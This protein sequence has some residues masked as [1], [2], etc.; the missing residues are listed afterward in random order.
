MRW[1]SPFAVVP[2]ALA[3]VG[4]VAT[5]VVVV[6]FLKNFDTPVVKASGREL[7]F[8]LFAGFIVCYLQTF[9]ILAKVRQTRFLHLRR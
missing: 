8:M 3:V 1:D 4:I 5:C 2:A 9:V 7:S 6:A